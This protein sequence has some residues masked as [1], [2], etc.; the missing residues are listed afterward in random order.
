[1]NEDAPGGPRADAAP[2]GEGQAV[3]DPRHGLREGLSALRGTRGASGERLDAERDAVSGLRVQA[4]QVFGGDSY[5]FNM[6]GGAAPVRS[7]RLS[8]EELDEVREAFVEPT[9]FGTLVG[10][11]TA[12]AV[13]V[14]RGPAGAGKDAMARAALHRAG[15]R[16]LFL[17]D[18]ATDLSRFEADDLQRGA[19]YVLAD[20]TQRAADALTSFELRRLDA[21]LR[22]KDCR[23]VLTAAAA[24]QFTDRGVQRGVVE[25]GE[26]PTGTEIV[27]SHMGWRLGIAAAARSRRILARSDVQE[28]LREEL[29]GTTAT[30][31][32]DLGRA[33]ADAAAAVADDQVVARVRERQELRDGQAISH[34][35]QNLDDLAQQCLAIGVS[36]F[37]GEAYEIVATLAR[38]LEE[39]LQVEESPDNPVRP[40]GTRLAGTRSARLDAI[41]GALVDSEVSTRHGGARGKVVRFQDP[42]VAVKV[43]EHV[44]SE[45]DEIREVLPVWLRDSAAGVL[46][47]VGVRAA[48]AAGV[49]AKHAFETVRARILFPWAADENAELRDAAAIALGVVATESGHALAA[50]NLVLAWSAENARPELQAT[51]ARAWRVVFERDGDERAW[52]WLHQLAAVEEVAVVEALCRSLTEYMALDEGRYRRDA[53]DLIDQWT[54]SGFHGTQ[55]RLVGELAF[56]YAAGDLVEP[57]PPQGGTDGGPAADGTG[58]WP[59]LLAV[60][61]RD[62]ELRTD[63]AALWR[64]TA[65]SPDVYEV[66]H[67]VLTEWAYLVETYP[68]GRSVLAALLEN[69][70]ADRRT[71]L[72]IRHLAAAWIRGSEGRGAPLTGRT[73]LA[74]LDGRSEAL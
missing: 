38:D 21:A 39:R 19:G 67:E 66:A 58:L 49:L 25:T 20:L 28:L 15:H 47:T 3:Q 37:G 31:A 57:R 52:A 11:V 43:L 74:Y 1:M 63:V 34:W 65:N 68:H 14:L 27:A 36:A 48:V 35:L 59:T 17:L 22:G 9:G 44:W 33:L 5:V 18:P 60:T 53:L 13:T 23:L 42:G 40:R 61:E 69:A 2:P 46:P 50:Y 10:E 73:V 70:A 45:Y 4:A 26:R 62:Q 32:A 72:I 7:Y 51:A 8:A 54:V 56:L 16:S 29:D 55:R 12:R 64:Q 30:A 41:H 6:A 24:I 71:E